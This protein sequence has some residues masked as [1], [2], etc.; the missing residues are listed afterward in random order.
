MFID[1]LAPLPEGVQACDDRRV[2]VQAFESQCMEETSVDSSFGAGIAAVGRPNT[3][4]Q[5]SV[6]VAIAASS[7][8]TLPTDDPNDPRSRLL[9]SS[10]Y[11]G[12]VHLVQ[13]GALSDETSTEVNGTRGTA[14]RYE[15]S[16]GGLAET[17][18][19]AA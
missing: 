8:T 2:V 9:N 11:R 6:V 19:T 17:M 7:Q 5:G 1:P 3:D 10:A 14:A 4:G 15:G 18:E 16:L 13:F 12:I